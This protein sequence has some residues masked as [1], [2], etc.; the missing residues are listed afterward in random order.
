MRTKVK[1]LWEEASAVSLSRQ[2]KRTAND[3]RKVKILVYGY[4]GLKLTILSIKSLSFY[5][6]WMMPSLS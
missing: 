1:R 3:V 5:F 6:I 2:K 4:L